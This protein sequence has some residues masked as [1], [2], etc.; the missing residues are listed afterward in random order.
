ME[1]NLFHILANLSI[2]FTLLM[3][4]SFLCFDKEISMLFF[5]VLY[6]VHILSAAVN[7]SWKKGREGGREKGRKGGVICVYIKYV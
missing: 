1:N 3:C 5:V 4:L 6:C 7:V 2:R